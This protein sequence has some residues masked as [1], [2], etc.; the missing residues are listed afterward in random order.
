MSLPVADI[1]LLF[2]TSDF[3]ARWNCGHWSSAHG[4]FHILS[5]IAIAAAYS[6][7]PLALATYWWFKRSEL[8]FPRL[9][10]L[11]AAFI[12]SCG[13]THLV[14]AIIFYAPVYRFSALM[15]FVTAVVSWATV[16]ALFR[17][18]PKAFELPGLRRVN[19]QLHDQLARTKQAEEALGRSNAELEAFTGIV[20]HDLRNPLNNALFMAEMAREAVACGDSERGASHLKIA[21]DSM[22]QMES[23]I[24]ELHACSKVFGRVEEMETLALESVVEVAT[25]N[26]TPLIE[27]SEAKLKVG[28]LPEVR[29]NRT[30]L[31]QLFINLFENSIKYRGQEPLVIGIEAVEEEAEGTVIRVT[32]TG[33]GIPREQI[34]QVFESGIRGD[35][36][37]SIPGS[38]L[39]LAFCRR[40]MEAHGGTISASNPPEGGVAIELRFGV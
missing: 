32:D 5:D 34:D 6:M 11:F 25:R 20:T 18:A 3:P 39:G 14:D 17:I 30:M 40:I 23:L 35:N 38:G 1:G 27:S 9:F 19:V 12:F 8:A 31:V 33:P 22:K 2:D 13:A 28:P 15:K 24:G 37:G 4:W 29:G 36:I 16:L 10:W 7:I 26:L 21:L